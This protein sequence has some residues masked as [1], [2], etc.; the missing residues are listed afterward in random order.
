MAAESSPTALLQHTEFVRQLARD[1]VG[2][3]D[4]GDELAQTVWL[5]ALQRPPRHDA[6]LR[7]W[8]ATLARRTWLNQARSARRRS[9]RERA[10]ARQETAPSP[11]EVLQ[12]ESARECVVRAL[13]VLDPPFREVLL[14]RYYEGMMPR[15]IARRLGVPP[16]TVR[17]RIARALRRLRGELDRS[18]GNAGGWRALLA[19]LL[20]P[21][22]GVTWLAGVTV[23]RL[24]TVVAAAATVLLSWSVWRGLR[25]AAAE[26]VVPVATAQL[27]AEAEP[28]VAA[29]EAAGENARTPVAVSAEPSVAAAPRMYPGERGVGGLRGLVIGAGGE[30]RADAT[31]TVEPYLGPL[32]PM[33]S[34][35]DDRAAVARA[36]TDARG[37]FSIDELAAGPVL[38]RARAPGLEAR[39][40]TAVAAGAPGAPLVLRME[41]A[42]AATDALRVLVVESGGGAPVEGAR[43]ELFGWASSNEWPPA[44]G[45][46]G[47]VAATTGA[48][49]VA[50]LARDGVRLGGVAA[51]APDGRLGWRSLPTDDRRQPVAL[52]VEV[53]SP[54]TV[55]GRIVGVPLA[56]VE[57]A[58]V[59]LHT[60]GTHAYHVAFGRRRDAVVRGGRYAF[61]GVPP[62]TH[63]LSLRST[64]GLRIIAA[65]FR[66]GDQP[67]ANSVSMPTVSVAAGEDVRHDLEVTVGG[68]IEGRVTAASLPVPGARVRAVLAPRTSNF[69]AGFVLH[70]VHVW[71]LDGGWENA[72]RNPAGHFAAVTDAAGRY[73]LDGLPPGRYR[74]E[75]AAAGWSFDRRMEV[76]V[77]DGA[78]VVEK[79]VLQPAGVLQLAVRDAVYVGVARP[80]A[81]RPHAIAVIRGGCATIPGLAEGSWVVGR[82]HSDVGVAVAPLATVEIVAGRTTWVDLRDRDVAARFSGRVRSG[83]A[84]VDGAVVSVGQASTVTGADGEF[85]LALGYRPDFSGSM[86]TSRLVVRRGAITYEC[87]PPGEGRTNSGDWSVQL[88]TATAHL[89][90]EGGGSAVGP[91]VIEVA[92]ARADGEIG[93]VRRVRVD[94]RGAS[95]AVVEIGP[96]PVWPLAGH[97]AFADGLRLPVALPGPGAVVRV[98]RPPTA[99]VRVRV[100]QDGVPAAGAWVRV[101]HWAADGPAPA[102]DEAFVQRAQEVAVSRTDADGRVAIS[103]P[104]GTVRVAASRSFSRSAAHRVV[105]SAGA[106][107]DLELELGR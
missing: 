1:L 86:P 61:E 71:R 68:R 9:E 12:R 36:R 69:T 6:S 76:A 59:T 38:V 91:A 21:R 66:W 75:V 31:V 78:T 107:A 37:R 39:R 55:S 51:T 82:Y 22:A 5:R 26:P 42:S 23:K 25:G 98:A 70:G 13:L 35:A 87:R 53:S 62:G 88:G 15:E 100:L 34:I 24:V 14:L 2:D 84:P 94:A 74:L 103:V 30:G 29:A 3:D 48:N 99:V 10:V 40:I 65:P 32:P 90:I 81:P 106:T 67:L 4:G 101:L 63:G 97:I 8:L 43:V 7:G 64:M 96:S 77:E 93:L 85:R 105:A 16:A 28:V 60:G 20:V 83:E 95:G 89:E 19:P 33:Q 18:A 52:H 41:P 49:G 54:G 92:G 47:I 50:V 17:T 56:Q 11:A 44:S 73:A 104:T 45:T 46:A 27:R 72:P 79:H 80:G 102:A 57:G 58:V